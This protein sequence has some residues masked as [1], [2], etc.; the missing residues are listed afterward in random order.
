M[1]DTFLLPLLF[2]FLSAFILSAQS[3]TDSEW[4]WPFSST[5]I[6]NM[7]LH[8]DAEYYFIGNDF[9]HHNKYVDD[10]FMAR[11]SASDPYRNV[12]KNDCG[13][14]GDKCRDCGTHPYLPARMQF[15]DMEIGCGSAN[16]TF[17]FVMPN[18][19][20][21]LSQ[22]MGRASATSDLRFRSWTGTKDIDICGDGL[23]RGGHGATELS[24]LGGTIRLGELVADAD[25]QHALKVTA[26]A[27]EYCYPSSHRWPA[28]RSDGYSN[29]YR[30]KRR[31]LKIG[32]LLALRKDKTIDEL[33][34]ETE[35]GRKLAK[36]MQTYGAYFVED[37]Y[38]WGQGAGA[39]GWVMEYGVQEETEQFYNIQMRGAGNNTAYF[40]DIDRITQNL[41]VI[42]NNGPST[43]GGGPNGDVDHPQHR[44][45]PLL[46][47]CGTKDRNFQNSDSVGHSNGSM[48]GTATLYQNYP[49]PFNPSTII[50][51]KLSTESQVKLDILDITG[52]HVV[53]LVHQV[54]SAGEHAV[55]F[56]G[57]D[58]PNSLYIYRLSAGNFTEIRKMI[59]LR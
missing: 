24:S 40:R 8:N 45:A 12:R 57:N 55:S 14:W 31:Q 9:Y 17:A 21:L 35:V 38:D 15:P 11:I 29:E 26:W 5:S 33:G 27:L 46:P 16:N 42:N 53:T 58:L 28:F 2:F 13:P 10:V 47:D 20:W 54:Q 59:L 56:A 6:W 50:R 25:I 30:G 3:P 51:Y 52:R 48:P 22:A 39:W 19:K 7:P 1:K 37:S 18:G 41:C 34:F 44:L 23:D 43:I 4:K 49:N 36:A 32:A